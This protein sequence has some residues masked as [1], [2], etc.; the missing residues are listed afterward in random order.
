MRL[1]EEKLQHLKELIAQWIPKK[2]ATKRAML[3]LIGEL[4]HASKVVIPGRTFLRRMID[5]THF[6]GQP[7][8]LDSTQ[9]GV[10][11]RP[12]L[13][14]PFPHSGMVCPC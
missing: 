8:A 14:A 2:A 4:A 12:S 5:T 6:K 3:S 10:Q 7:G 9:P 1:P 11:I 13:V